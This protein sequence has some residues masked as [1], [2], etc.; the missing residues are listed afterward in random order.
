MYMYTYMYIH[1]Y[2]TY[3]ATTYIYI[4]MCT[5]KAEFNLLCVAGRKAVRAVCIICEVNCKNEGGLKSHWKFKHPDLYKTARKIDFAAGVKL[6]KKRQSFPLTMK[7]EALERYFQLELDGHPEPQRIVTIELFGN[8]NYHRRKSYINKW[9]NAVAKFRRDLLPK[10][11]GWQKTIRKQPNKRQGLFPNCEDELYTR[12]LNRRG[13]KGWPANHFWLQLEFGR[14]LKEEKPK[15]HEGFKVSSGWG[16]GFC[17]RFR[18]TSQAK[19]NIK[20]HDATER[21]E[22]IIKF[23]RYFA[24]VQSALSRP[25]TERSEKYGRFGPK[26]MFHV[27]QVPLP[28]ASPCSKTLNPKGAKSCRI[29]APK[30]SG[31]EK[32][33]ATLQLWICADPE[34][35]CITPAL[36]FRGSRG[37]RS[38]LPWPDEKELYESLP[39]IRVHFQKNA[40]AD[41]TFC[42]ADIMEVS[43]CLQKSG[44]DCEV[45]IGMDNHQ[46]Q[47]TPEMMATYLKLGMEIMFTPAS[48]TDCTSPVDHHVGRF[49][50]NKMAQMYA[51]EVLEHPEIWFQTDDDD[52]ELEDTQGSSAKA[53]RMK[54]AT[55]LSAAWEDLKTNHHRLLSQAFVATGFLVA[56]DGSEDH[57]IDLQ[58][59]SH[60]DPYKFREPGELFESP[61]MS[62]SS[63]LPWSSSSSSSS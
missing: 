40:W 44:L 17:Q 22:K 63:S 18:I 59:W 53:R 42:H 46:S 4:A 13:H 54:M 56:L 52:Q 39:G 35:Q 30:T 6:V 25:G 1:T 11:K 45:L 55:W 27:D 37:P 24:Q 51:G 9:L 41:N 21:K 19:N 31:L 8:A 43:K 62:S 60:Q 32:R 14:I 10:L 58:G 16:Q 15:G 36:I 38:K 2:I 5:Y 34:N 20:T 48:C 28:F 3:I 26:N 23:H 7:V 57:L 12:F 50:Q 61:I 47:R 33:Q 29:A 49:I